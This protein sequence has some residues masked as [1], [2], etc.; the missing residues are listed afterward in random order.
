MRWIYL[1]LPLCNAY[2]SVCILHN[3][4]NHIIKNIHF[5]DIQNSIIYN[6]KDLKLSLYKKNYIYCKKSF[7]KINKIRNLISFIM[8]LLFFKFKSNSLVILGILNYFLSEEF[9]KLFNYN[10][11][12]QL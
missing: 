6:K 8:L 7:I 5:P 10:F 2:F 3:T 11:Y 1:I 4:R 9:K 12:V